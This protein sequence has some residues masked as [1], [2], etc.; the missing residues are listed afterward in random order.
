[1]RKKNSL[2]SNLFILFKYKLNKNKILI[3]GYFVKHKVTF[4]L[5]YLFLIFLNLIYELNINI[6]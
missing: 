1:M 3:K 6:F 4:I 5:F 2:I